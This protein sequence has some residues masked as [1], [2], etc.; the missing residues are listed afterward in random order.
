MI[1]VR[2]VD[3]I[4]LCHKSAEVC[5]NMANKTQKKLTFLLN[6]L[7]T[8]RKFNGVDINQTKHFNHIHCSTY[9]NK[10]V[11]H[12]QWENEPC[13]T[14]PTPFGADNQ[15]QALI[16]TSR[17]PEDPKDAL[18]LQKHMGFN[19]RQAI[20]ELIYAYTICRIDIAIAV[21]VITLS[22]FSHH[23][24]KVHYEA[25]KQVF[26]YMKSTKDYVLTYWR[27]TPRDDLPEKSE[28]TPI[29]PYHRLADYDQQTI[30][31]QLQGCCDA[32]CIFIVFLLCVV[33]IN[34]SL[35]QSRKFIL[36]IEP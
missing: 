4:L 7:G 29:S 27:P 25:I 24:A 18:K 31:I 30:A 16:Q 17:G 36:S 21:A 14:P 12:H 13:R 15:Y 1:I 19:Y 20:G 33:L 23:P 11:T 5:D 32:T 10:I 28:P 3:D 8:V 34:W 22:Q 2:Q 35:D 26:V 9:I 6:F